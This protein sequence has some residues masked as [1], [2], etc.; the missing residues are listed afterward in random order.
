MPNLCHYYKLLKFKHLQIFYL[1]K[2]VRNRYTLVLKR[3]FLEGMGGN[4][5]QLNEKSCLF[6]RFGFVFFAKIYLVRVKSLV[7][8]C[9]VPGVPHTLSALLFMDSQNLVNQYALKE[10]ELN[11]LLEVTQAINNNLS[12]ESLYKI[13]NFTLR[14]NL[15]IK[16]LA[17]YVLNE[18]DGSRES[19]EC[20]ANFGTD[21]DFSEVQLLPDFFNID[22]TTEINRFAAPALF[23]EFDIYIPVSHKDRM[24]A[25]VFIG[26]V[27]APDPGSPEISIN[28]IEALSNIIVV[29]IENKKL[30]RRQ[31]EQEAMRKEMEIA[32]EVQQFLF[33]KVMPDEKGLRVLATY[34]PHYS[35]GGDYYDFL[36]F[37]DGKFGIAIGD[38]SGKGIGAS[39]M[40]ASL[41][42]SLRG[43]AIHCQDDLAELMN[44]VNTLLYDAS[45]SNRYATFF[46]A[47]YDTKTRRLIYVNA[48]HNPPFLIRK[49]NGDFEVFRLEE[50]G[51]VVGMLASMFVNY[52][53]GEIQIQPG[54]LLVGFTDG[55]SEAMN[56]QEEEWSE[57]AMLEELKKV[58]EKPS[59]EI[60]NYIVTQ[61][62]EFANGAKQHDDMTMIIVK[63]RNEK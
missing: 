13:F 63:V 11:A 22:S 27:G 62:D 50:G 61:A 21:T 5:L 47:L 32:R 45:T 23:Q 26:G 57:E 42:A 38:V 55:I 17:L 10:L 44:H 18:H 34:L 35:V 39:L 36:E 20:K 8:A 58:T 46:F 59:E 16:K 49:T 40:M 15:Q 60:L 24:L 1:F 9:P 30:A 6:R 53:Q 25:L 19:W 29:A 14:A 52:K 48:G 37:P 33:P 56:P 2:D 41:Q 3:T 12:E 43:Q 4:L 31:L 7:H 28:F 54:D 51:A